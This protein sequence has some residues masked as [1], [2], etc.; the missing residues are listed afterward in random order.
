MNDINKSTKHTL[1]TLGGLMNSR[2]MTFSKTLGEVLHFRIL[3][4]TLFIWFLVLAL[5]HRI[6][7]TRKNELNLWDDAKRNA[8]SIAPYAFMRI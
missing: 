5:V 7:M 6:K 3:F 8:S 1:V 4:A 2:K